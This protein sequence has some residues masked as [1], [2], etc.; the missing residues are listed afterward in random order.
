[1]KKIIYIDDLETLRFLILIAIIASCVYAFGDAL[2]SGEVAYAGVF[3]LL[4]SI[5]GAKLR[6]TCELMMHEEEG[7]EGR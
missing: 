5:A 2:G 4:A 7:N 1:M 6:I 3:A